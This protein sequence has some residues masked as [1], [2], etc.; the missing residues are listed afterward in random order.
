M[1][2][3]IG[4]GEINISLSKINFSSGETVKGRITLN[5]K[6]PKLARDLM[7]E[8]YGESAD[9]SYSIK[10]TRRYLLRQMLCGEKVYKDGE[11]FRFEFKLP[12][13][14]EHKKTGSVHLAA[15]QQHMPEKPSKWFVQASLNMPLSFDLN[16]RI[17]IKIGERKGKQE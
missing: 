7:L 11:I 9:D 3:G 15:L 1:V 2:L 17:G 10:E 6:R 12:D 16:H 5:L 4:E 8:V 13:N 14:I